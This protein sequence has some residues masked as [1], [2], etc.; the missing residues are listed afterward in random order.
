MCKWKITKAKTT[1]L[2]VIIEIYQSAREFMIRSGNP[3]QWVNYPEVELLYNDIA[4][5]KL[6]VCKKAEEIVGVFYYEIAEDETY[7]NIVG[8]W[9]NLDP[10]GVVH[11][12][13]VKDGNKGVGSFCLTYALEDCK[14]LKI[15]TH[16]DNVP[17]RNLL[18]KMGFAYCGMI[19]LQNG[20]KRMAYQKESPR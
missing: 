14:N 15:D 20:D 18:E 8:E 17:M 19:T 12:I 9:L 4:E 2:P 11:R 5:G 13:A 6:F 3:K 1:D 10:Y 16:E 7:R